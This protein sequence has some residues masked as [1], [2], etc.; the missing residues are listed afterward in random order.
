MYF[1]VETKGYDNFDEISTKEKIQ[2]KSA[3][4]FFKQLKDQGVNVEYRTKLNSPELSQMISD[5]QKN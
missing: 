3:E 2:I 5:I 4:A 1:I